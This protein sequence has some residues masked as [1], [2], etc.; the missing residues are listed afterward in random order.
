MRAA[1]VSGGHCLAPG[2]T[3]EGPADGAAGRYAR[4]FPE[5]PPV[6]G[7]NAALLSLGAAGGVCDGG[8]DCADAVETAA[9]WPMFGQYVAHDITADRS[10]IGARARAA[11]IAN[12]RSPRANLESLYGSGQIGS[13]F[14][15][16]VEDPDLLL[17]GANDRGELRDLPRNS[18]GIALIGDPRNDVHLFVSQLQVAMIGVHNRLVERARGDGV[19]AGEVFATAQRQTAWHYQWVILEDYLPRLVGAELAAEVREEG[20][21][22]YRPGADP[23]IPFE[24]AD[25]AFRYG[26][27]QVRDEF[28]VNAGSAARRLFPDLLGF[29]PVPAELVVDWALLFDVE[30]RPPAQRAKRIDG[31][32]VRSLIELPAAVTGEVEVDA[33]RS[34]AGRD[35][36]RGHAYGLPSGEDVARAMGE[37]PLSAEESDLAAAGWDGGTPLWLYFMLES[38]ARGEGERLGPCGGRIVAEVLTGLI[39]A[40]PESYRSLELDWDPTLPS[41]GDRFGLADL[42]VPVDWR[43][44]AMLLAGRLN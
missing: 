12:F 42:L 16:R 38:A 19:Q 4:L 11:R 8:E 17:L 25:A 32:L 5:L 15:F 26:H 41:R 39:D 7:E 30:G 36:E 22:F 34:L 43:E 23:K 27:G 40:D 24:F 31:T 9:G 44:G 18:Q 13:P 29:R 14:L 2:R 20:P 6:E 33:Y 3:V 35:L 10:P 21:R 28:E 1:T 37:T